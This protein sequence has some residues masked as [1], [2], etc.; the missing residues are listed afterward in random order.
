M[1]YLN[2][3][4]QGYCNEN[5]R[6]H[7]VD[8]FFSE[9]KKA[10][11]ENF[12]SSDLFFGG[13]MKIIDALNENYK[14]QIFEQQ[15][16]LNQ[17]LIS[18]AENID[19]DF[20]KAFKEQIEYQKLNGNTNFRLKNGIML[21][22]KK[23]E[24]TYIEIA[25]KKAFQLKSK[26][27]NIDNNSGLNPTDNFELLKPHRQQMFEI[28]K[29]K[30]IDFRN[31]KNIITNEFELNEFY[32]IWLNDELKTI[33]GW[34]I[35]TPKKLPSNI[36]EIK[37]YENYV[38]DK[39]ASLLKALPPQLRKTNDIEFE[40]LKNEISHSLMN[41]TID[42]K[43]EWFENNYS[44]INENP[45][46]EFE[47]TGE[48]SFCWT[49]LE[50]KK[51]NL[52]TN[53]EDI[54]DFQIEHLE[55]LIKKWNEGRAKNGDNAM[56]NVKRKRLLEYYKSLKNKG[57]FQQS[58][59]KTENGTLKINPFEEIKT[60][61]DNLKEE[62]FL[63]LQTDKID[64]DTPT[65]FEKWNINAKQ[66]I[67]ELKNKYENDQL[68]KN[69]LIKCIE[70]IGI[71]VNLLKTNLDE[72]FKPKKNGRVWGLMPLGILKS[73]FEFNE[74]INTSLELLKRKEPISRE[75]K[76]PQQTNKP[77]LS[78]LTI[79]QKNTLAVKITG[80]GKENLNAKTQ[81]EILHIKPILSEN[82]VTPLQ[83]I[84]IINDFQNTFSPEFNRIMLPKIIS[85]LRDIPKIEG[86]NINSN[87]EKGTE[88]KIGNLSTGIIN[89]FCKS[90]PLDI[91][92]E[93]FKVF[94]E[95]NS[96][97]KKTFLTTEQYNFFIE[98][99]FCGNTGLPKQKFNQ[100]PKGEKLLIQ[101]VFY[102][103]Y[104]NYCMDYF[105]TMQC[106]E[107]FIKLLTEN[108]I[109]WDFKNVKENFNPKTKKRL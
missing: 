38:N 43:I 49:I 63:I 102:D 28:E 105:S 87:Q 83:A 95:T 69:D 48:D 59:T 54:I 25:I 13:C 18:P 31:E 80:Y 56:F 23:D 8:Y 89:V 21:H 35:R 94:I 71:H 55:N 51:Q 30:F 33:E 3:V 77:L 91:A 93:H 72:L 67:N 101:A 2:I 100:I 76:T 45:L 88:T 7:L 46:I 99:A 10:E 97:N 85:Y 74:F 84:D 62:I 22:L 64:N 41:K 39:I 96:K 79:E 6:E 68:I 86:Q 19:E 107:I 104:N 16:Q 42:E 9:F 103:F 106:Q 15:H 109:G 98:R 5:N 32:L 24:I 81:P 60:V 50:Y 75:F 37:K 20:V 12:C 66:K 17:Y 36:V 90:M 44:K 4:L 14:E 27:T 61:E 108:F 40:N 92:K 65:N 73:N 11:K 47:L 1:D 78:E 52:S 29:Q 26:E 53:K 70:R 57:S 82:N 34:L 58:E